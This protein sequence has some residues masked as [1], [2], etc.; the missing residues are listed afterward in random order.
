MANDRPALSKSFRKILTRWHPK[1]KST[2]SL[3]EISDEASRAQK[4]QSKSELTGV[5]KP[6]EDVPAPGEEREGTFSTVPH[7]PDLSLPE[8]SETSEAAPTSTTHFPTE[9]ISVA[10]TPSEGPDDTDVD[11]TVRSDGVS[12]AAQANR[13]LQHVDNQLDERESRIPQDEIL[14]T[15]GEAGRPPAKTEDLT[16][17]AYTSEQRDILGWLSPTKFDAKHWRLRRDIDWNVKT[18]G[19]W[20]LDEDVFKR[21]KNSPRKYLWLQGRSGC[22]KSYLC[23]TVIEALKGELDKGRP[24]A[25]AYWY[26]Q[27]DQSDT[28]DLDNLLSSLISQLAAT[29]SEFPEE[30]K[31]LAEVHLEQNSRPNRDLLIQVL[32]A[33][34]SRLDRDV[35]IVLDGLDEYPLDARGKSRDDLLAGIGALVR[36]DYGN[37]HV[38][39]AGREESDINN[40]LRQLENNGKELFELFNIE[41]GVVSDIESF[42][43]NKVSKDDHLKSLNKKVKKSIIRRLM[44]SEDAKEKSPS[45]LLVA[46]MMQELLSC[47]G[48]EKR[49]KA[50][51][52]SIPPTMEK[53]FE[54]QLLKVDWD[55]V[56][57]LKTVLIWLSESMR[58]LTRDEVLQLTGVWKDEELV[59]I[60][61]SS[62]VRSYWESSSAGDEY[63]IFGFVHFSAKE[64]L[65]SPRLRTSKN[66]KLSRFFMREDEKHT[67]IAK[68]CLDI[69]LSTTGDPS[70]RYYLADSVYEYTAQNWFRHVKIATEEEFLKQF[71]ESPILQLLRWDSP[72]FH[73]WLRI[74][75][76]DDSG[77]P[78][79]TGAG[80][81][82]GIDGQAAWDPTGPSSIAEPLYYAI[83]L[84]LLI[85]AEQLI[86]GSANINLRG[87]LEGTA[88]QLASFRGYKDIVQQLLDRGAEVNAQGKRRGSAL[89]AAASQGNVEIVV[90]LLGARADANKQEE[91]TFGNALQVAAYRG[92][93]DIVR[94]L[95][96]HGADANAVGGVMYNAL[97]AASAAGHLRTVS[98]LIQGG[99]LVNAAGGPLGTALVAALTGGHDEVVEKLEA[100]GAERIRHGLACWG[101]AYGSFGYDPY[102]Y[103]EYNLVHGDYTKIILHGQRIPKELVFGDQKLM[104]ATLVRLPLPHFDMVQLSIDQLQRSFLLKTPFYYQLRAIQRV[105]PHLTFDTAD[106]NKDGFRYRALFWA[107]IDAVF[108][109]LPS[110]V[111]N[112]IDGIN[113]HAPNDA[114]DL[115]RPDNNASEF[116]NYLENLETRSEGPWA[117]SRRQE[118][119]LLN[120]RH[121]NSFT[122]GYDLS[123][124]SMAQLAQEQRRS[125][126]DPDT[127]TAELVPGGLVL[128]DVLGILKEIIQIGTNVDLYEKVSPDPK[129][130]SATQL[131][132][133][134]GDLCYELFLTLARLV[135][136]T[137]VRDSKSV[138]LKTIHPKVRLLR[139]V[140]LERI[141]ALDAFCQQQ[142]ALLQPPKQDDS[143]ALF[144]G[145]SANVADQFRAT[146][147]QQTS[148]IQAD[149]TKQL[150]GLQSSIL[151]SVKRQISAHIEAE[152]GMFSERIAAEVAEKIH[153]ELPNRFHLDS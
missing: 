80:E 69:L 112:F 62:L 29:S 118:Y 51:L 49:V 20:L 76:P 148:E 50:K 121:H 59:R 70:T 97:Q 25:L 12:D 41:H 75:N 108:E 140:P 141:K 6:V 43:S 122:T 1:A 132:K 131:S 33:V 64:Y 101:S 17:F 103:A 91:T 55:D 45:F 151:D 48:D 129:K 44:K 13:Q 5:T 58:P 153:L 83:H 60:C 56:D 149:I 87:G 38:L 147:A 99:A 146:T 11:S 7:Q 113:H 95:I 119:P 79:S 93:D 67:R 124:V 82:T 35:Y 150:Q 34:I 84:E 94:L 47:Q 144:K 71:K 18:S 152:L 32:D 37:I 68:K 3:L 36:K 135:R 115:P 63:Q 92:F 72:C 22:G 134:I 78:R 116:L 100:E 110:L 16:R 30:I 2:P 14:A 142:A 40:Y 81:S 117:Q 4:G 126:A 65:E 133:G 24:K 114:P 102:S 109:A 46:S 85:T 19:Q 54:E 123:D 39:V 138:V 125:E 66:A 104:A 61:P 21:W 88:L 15:P 53:R 77:V 105:T 86:N 52:K 98:I 130:E 107:G 120:R 89:Y 26:I 42:V 8:N 96:I 136:L 9:P 145:I 90:K 137:D 23:S 73:S 128:A 139:T 106:L 111:G 57:K 28:Q 10:S 31:N 27:Y 143:L 74:F 127:P